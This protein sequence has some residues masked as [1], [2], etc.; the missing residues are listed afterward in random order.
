MHL[1]LVATL[2]LQYF[3]VFKNLIIFGKKSQCVYGVESFQFHHSPALMIKSLDEEKNKMKFYF[4]QKNSL[5]ECFCNTYLFK[6][7]AEKEWTI[8]QFV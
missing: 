4:T 7:P 3:M 8:L 6:K 2:K 5:L 1:P